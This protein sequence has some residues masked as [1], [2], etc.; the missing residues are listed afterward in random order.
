MNEENGL[1]ASLPSRNSQGASASVASPSFMTQATRRVSMKRTP[2]QLAKGEEESAEQ[3]DG[4]PSRK[5]ARLSYQHDASDGTARLENQPLIQH[6]EDE[7]QLEA[8]EQLQLQPRLRAPGQPSRGKSLLDVVLSPLFSAF[9]PRNEL[10]DH[11]SKDEKQSEEDKDVDS[12]LDTTG[13]SVNASIASHTALSSEKLSSHHNQHDNKAS[14]HQIS[15][16]AAVRSAAVAAAAAAHGREAGG[17]DDEEEEDSIDDGPEEEQ[18]DARL[19][20]TTTGYALPSVLTHAAISIAE[21]AARACGVHHDPTHHH[22]G[23]EDREDIEEVEEEEEEEEVELEGE[24]EEEEEEEEAE[25]NPF[26]FI[27]ALPP[28]EQCVPLH[29][30]ALLPRQTRACQGKKTLILDLDETLVHSSLEPGGGPKGSDFS[31]DV[32]FN[33]LDHVIFVRKRPHLA[34]FMALAASLFEVVVFTASQ[35]VYAEKLLNIIDPERKLIKHRIFRDS[36][37]IIEGNYLKDLTCL[38]RDMRTT[39]IVDNSPQ[40]FG[41]QPDNG[42]PIESWYDDERDNELMKLWPFLRDLASVE[43]VRP[44]IAQKYRL[45]QLINDLKV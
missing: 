18:M 25:F 29:R 39:F 11:L 19:N 2:E 27:K 22:V 23:G 40:A 15:L 14:F 45:R 10:D 30:M 20:S 5:R 8:D 26:L 42:I 9:L 6:D 38:G 28:L 31:F 13:S 36:C 37:V 44:H 41:F 24:G 12:G 21:M 4:L 1:H 16:Q 34:S 17:T 43:D 3:L 33:N 35:K 32:R 7:H